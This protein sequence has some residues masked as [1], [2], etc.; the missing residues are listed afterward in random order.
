MWETLADKV[1]FGMSV[2]YRELAEMSGSPKAQQAVGTA[3]KNNPISLI[4]P[5]HRVILSSG[6]TGNYGG[7][8]R[9]QLKVWLLE[10]EKRVSSIGWTTGIF[11]L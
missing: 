5:C 9:N 11:E 10:H 6:K 7:G 4:V 2:S 8:K 1:Q 3:M